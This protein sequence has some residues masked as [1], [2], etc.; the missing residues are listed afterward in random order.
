[1]KEEWEF[2]IETVSTEEEDEVSSELGYCL[3][4]RSG[5]KIQNSLGFKAFEE[6]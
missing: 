6:E 4:I 3:L 2:E 1:M 5:E